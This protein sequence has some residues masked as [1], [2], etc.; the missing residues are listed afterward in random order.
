MR[1]IILAE[2]RELFVLLLFTFFYSSS[3]PQNSLSG[4]ITG[5]ESGEP[6][7]GAVVYLP[8]LKTGATTGEKGE[9]FISN[10][11][12]GKFIIEVKYLGYSS[13]L[14]KVEISGPTHLNVTLE[15]SHIEIREVVV[16]GVSTSTDKKLNPMPVMAVKSG[17]FLLHP[18]ANI[19]DAISRK[20][21][22]SQITT[23]SA[24]SKP[25]I[26]GLGYNRVVTLFNGFRQEGQQ[27]GDEHGV[28]ID[29]NS[30]HRVEI[31]K[32]PG[33]LIYG[34][35]AIAGVVNFIPPP[36]AEAGTVKG[37]LLMNYQSNNGLRAWS[38][39]NC[40]NIKNVFW[41]VRT[42]TKNAGNFTNRYDGKVYNSGFAEMD[43]EAFS[44][45]TGKWGF[46]QLELSRFNLTAGMIGGERDS[47]GKFL[48]SFVIKDTVAGTRPVSRYELYRKVIEVP[49]QEISHTRAGSMNNLIIGRSSLR[50]NAAIQQ[51]IR[52]EFSNVFDANEP[53]MVL[54]LNTLNYDIKYVFPEKEGREFVCGLNGM[55][56]DNKN[57]GHEF[58]IPDYDLFDAGGFLTL[59]QETG[60]VHLQGGI[61]YD[62]R[63]I[64][65]Y[66]L[67]L[68]STGVPAS[69]TSGQGIMKKFSSLDKIFTSPSGSFGLTVVNQKKNVSGKFNLSRGFRT[70]NIAELASNGVHEGTFRYETGN[71]NLKPETVTQL[72]AGMIY[73]NDHVSFDF[74][75][76]TNY[77][78]NFIFLQNTGDYFTGVNESGLENVIPVYR[79]NQTDAVIRGG[80]VSLDLHFHPVD[81]LHFE[82]S[83]SYLENTL[84][85]M[86][87]SMQHIPFSP[88]PRCQS[89]LRADISK[90]GKKFRN[91]YA[92]IE[93]DYLFL[94]KNIFLAYG[95]ETVTPSYDL[96]NA[97]AGFTLVSKSN[98][99]N[100]PDSAQGL[101]SRPVKNI[102][103]VYFS[104]NNIFDTPY[105]DHLSRLKYAP[106]NPATGRRG[107]FNMGRNFS[108]KVIIPLDIAG[109]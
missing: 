44:G 13:L 46:S 8:D 30:V 92:K 71:E 32:G 64:D 77:I 85:G 37:E 31:V 51:N 106:V 54:R 45:T 86:P 26:R 94:Q 20:P 25:V 6:L 98:P 97:G 50:I 10:L 100:F 99:T 87:D 66:E 55:F 79:F 4:E 96:F 83:F 95:T 14:V 109:K 91:I 19:I 81:W 15:P 34:S 38:A 57:S 60:R 74:A 62:F 63:D 9:Y 17:D 93:Y 101:M 21:G 39:M 75:V 69:S 23:G 53:E 89:E 58:L 84:T 12:A 43:A 3:F 88:P 35:D 59:K 72:D 82:N 41:N 27:W 52:K 105:Q 103:S 18:S 108:V 33:S 24:I 36:P 68:D 107:I 22:I 73:E 65:A 76:F 40:G 61:R 42:T 102:L 47:T 78:R 49:Y 48:K 70:P 7:Y 5:K 1:R 80:E 11:P 29:E 90:A 104:V 2:K 56:Q 67:F 16:T 28:E